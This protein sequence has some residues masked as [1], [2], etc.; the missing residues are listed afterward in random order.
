MLATYMS[1]IG[2]NDLNVG[3]AV[4]SFFEAMAQAVYRASGDTFAILRDFSV[5]RA[6]G[7]AL[8]RL[9][10][11]E[12]LAP[13]TARVATGKVTITD[14]SFTKKTTKIYAGSQP[15]NIGSTVISVSDA[16]EFDASG[17]IYIGRGTVN[18]EGPIAYGSITPIG[19]YYNINLSTP[20]TKYHNLSENVILAQ[21]G[22]R[23]IPAGTLVKT[24]AAGSSPEINFSV[25]RNVTML[26]GEDTIT[27][28]PVAAQ[29]P[30]T[31]G[32]IPRNAIK[33]FASAPFTG[34]TVYNPNP[35]TTGRNEETD[36]EIR[37]RIKKA[38]ISRGLGT[39]I[40]VKNAVLG[41]QASDENAI[42]ISDEIFSDGEETVLFIDNGNGYE[43]KTKGVGL[44][45]LVD[46]ALGG[47][48]HFQLATSGTQT[49]LAKA[50]L[51]STETAPFDI[52]PNDRLSILVGGILSEHVFN[53][54]DFRADGF[55]TAYEI[56][57]SINAN[58]DLKFSA[59]TV[60]NG[61]KVALQAKT[62]TSE[63][64]QKT[65]P[66]SGTDAGAALGLTTSEVETLR[67]Y[68]NNKPLSRNG[69][70]ALIE[71]E[72]QT[73]W[74]NTITSGETLKI[75][76]DGTAQITY[77][78]T[79]SDFL[80]EGT[81]PTVSKTNTL[82]SWVNVLNTKVTGITASI[83]GNRIVL[84]SN[85]GTKARAQIVIDPTST[86]V[87]KGMFTANVGL[88]ATGAEADFKLSRNTA[89]IRLTSPLAAGDSLT[90]GSEFTQAYV[91]SDALLGGSVTFPDDAQMWVVVDNKDAQIINH[92]VLSDSLVYITKPGG[93]RLRFRASF[94]NAFSEVQ[95]GDYVVIWSQE[96]VT[97]NRLEGRVYARGTDSL[98]NDY[99]EIRVTSAEYLGVA[100]EGPVPF[101]EGLA[102]IRSEIPPQKVQIAAG[103]YNINTIAGYLTEQI[104]GV[105]ATT[106]NDEFIAITSNNKDLDGSVLI[107]TF[108]D[109]AKNLNF[110]LGDYAESSFSHF[111]FFRND[112]NSTKFP[113]FV[114]SAMAQDRYADTPN[115][116]IPDFE[117]AINLAT[118]GIDP[119]VI[120]AMKNP[121]LSSG[122]YIKDSQ[123]LDQS[124]QIDAISGTT[125][126][127]DQT[128]TI[129]R[130]RIDDRYVLL[131]PLDFDYADTLI[132]VLD[133]NPAEKTFPINLYRRATTNTTMTINSNQFRAYDTDAGATTQ[134]AEF[135]GSSYNFKNYKVMMMAKNVLDPQ[136]ATNEDAILYR[137]ALWGV[138][139]EKYRVGYVYPTAANQDVTSAVIVDSN[140]NIRIGLKSGA[141]IVNSID[142]TTEWDVTIT[143]NTPVAGVDEVT[144][145]WNGTGTN[146]N[147][148]TLAPGH[149]V[150]INGS[151]EF[152]AANTGVFRVSFAT[153]TSFTV[154][155]PNGEAVAENN[156]ASLTS[157]TISLYQ[158]SATTAADIQSYV[159]ANLGDW[160]T[161]TLID[162]AGLTGAG[163][164]DLSTYEDNDFAANSEA[165]SLLDGVNWISSSALGASAPLAQFFLKKTLSLPSFSTNTPNAYA[166][167]NAEELRIIPTTIEQVAE[168]MSVLA[169][170]GFTTLGAISVVQRDQMLQLATQILGSSGSV[171][172]S[173]GTG[174]TSK[175]LVLGT[176]SL[177]NGT[178]LMQS[179]VSKA[180]ASGI[181]VG[182]FVKL[183]ASNN[184]KKNTGISFTTNATIVPVSP[185]PTTS[186]ITLGNRDAHD[187]FFGQPR[188][189]FRDRTRA[190]HVE[191]HGSLVN[192]SWDGVTGGNPVFSKTVEFNDAGGGNMSVV[193]DSDNNF[194][195]YTR[196]S[197]SRNFSEVQPGDSI[198][199]QN[200][201]DAGNNGT[202]VVV[203]TSDNGLTIVVDNADG[204][205]A[206]SAAV[207][208]GD[209]VITTDI[210]EGDLVEIS[211]PFSTLNQG[212][213]RVVRRYANSIY[214][215]NP[216]AVEERVVVS[217]NLRSLGFDAT[218]T[219]N[220][221]V[222][223]DMKL[224][225]GG[226][227]TVP[228]LAN[229]KMGDIVTIGTAFAA[230]N[231]GTF[232][233]TESGSN[234][235]K[236][237]NSKAVAQSGIL[238]SGVGGD[239]IQAH[240]PAMI[241]SPYDNTR[242]G[243]SFVISGDV[244]TSSNQGIWNV[245]DVLSK[246]QIVVQGT[247]TAQSLVQFNNLFTQVYV[248]EASPYVGYK[249]VYSKAID[250]A[251]LQRYLLLFDTNE[252][253][254]KINEAAD[255]LMSAMSKLNYSS[256]T[257][258]GYDSYKH[259]IGLIA[260]ANK[261][262][263]GDPRDSVTY[264]GVAAAGAEIFIKPPLVRRITVSINVRVQTGIPF[265]RITEQV[266][267]NIAALINST[268]IGESIAISDIISTVNSIPGTRAISISSPT[269][270]PLNDIIVVNP[271]E[272]P[273]VLDIVNDIQ[274]SKVD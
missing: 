24:A 120:M 150:N 181:S 8:Q 85:L 161:A 186:T 170:T 141:A 47:E 11:E 252:Q 61:T 104:A 7:E 111:G 221:T 224:E 167:N 222:S 195:E 245:V 196:T 94:A 12:G 207:A 160:I 270:D 134:F 35:F 244:L 236:L 37:N 272:K 69:R 58:S 235:I 117:S 96:L 187:R 1:K 264:P 45:F 139:G 132:A 20:T 265:S 102:F 76:V 57:S 262:V 83:N 108:N 156:I 220:I 62:E 246:S 116:Y 6:E 242:A 165:I 101:F 138:G 49:S 77:T 249:R 261:I 149:Y 124:V 175:A 243:D 174:N 22:T 253:Y 60:D 158:N 135:F 112:E 36:Q 197:G 103:S 273:F 147:M 59:T 153:S 68:K 73:D 15:P 190:F 177:I 250:P 32:N 53:S 193:F 248:E 119:N 239:V 146:P 206:G 194:T 257:I 118:L 223:G 44:E 109:S 238:V 178:S 173:G 115:A 215:D 212:Q 201:A 106:E 199:I 81:H 5:D 100:V 192:I 19:G 92:G 241:F 87:A 189:I 216:S 234:Y 142:G 39:A 113:L 25:T 29:E 48:D 152:S 16:S 214:I 211:S 13:I 75:S 210:R 191:K 162:D 21:G 267:N 26:D 30:G 140:V 169:V 237:A 185:T 183:V 14:S 89:Q 17:S 126:D 97:G 71:S 232:M 78:I 84:T 88:S 200:F 129:R 226:S 43:E 128:N 137:S 179:S 50:T 130:V 143:P 266:R 66:T 159:V 114:H 54:G 9:R 55:A 260:E 274:V 163:V 42:V 28:V 65:N 121:Y 10:E 268:A 229:A 122:N 198:T 80:S 4:T 110:T 218:T 254:S 182:Q 157:T 168:F 74:S 204:V 228:T 230:A 79:N 145:T 31:D 255:V 91:L 86:L 269:Y 231:Q 263:Y 131:N 107:F 155:R 209:M 136:S 3:N 46:S 56:V 180:S 127:I 98:T 93:N 205:T 176:S 203:G 125:I 123:G 27:D 133:G 64:L 40:A 251:N 33:D 227:G 67:L 70:T 271:A 51:T 202:F 41:A 258:A 188:N 95:V 184:Q 247:M 154:R 38:R 18:V 240:I 82:Q 164:I 23:N 2:V 144:Y 171:K 219:F 52:S 151:G 63:Y 225:Y 213:F 72:N 90:A 166:F 233:V 259:H 208:P 34:A 105:V 217:S 172:L 99:F 148:A 256:S